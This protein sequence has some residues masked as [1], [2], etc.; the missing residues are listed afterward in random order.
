MRSHDCER[1]TPRACA[2]SVIHSVLGRLNVDSARTILMTLAETVLHD[3]QYGVRM[4]FRNPGATA[5]TVLALAL[6]IGVNTAVFTAY[7]AMVA[8]PLDARAPSEMVNLALV[9]DSS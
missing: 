9:R 7:K 3:L 6:G 2:T 4:L 8:R 5:V 1:G